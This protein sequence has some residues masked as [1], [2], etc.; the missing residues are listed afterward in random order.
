[1]PPIEMSVD[2]EAPTDLV[3]TDKRRS[4]FTRSMRFRRWFA[5]SRVTHDGS[6]SGRPIMVFRGCPEGEDRAARPS[7]AIFWLTSS[8]LNACFFEDG[9]LQNA[10][11]R[12]HRPLVITEAEFLQNRTTP[13]RIAADARLQVEMGLA[14]WDGVIFE[15]IVDGSHPSTV[16]AVFPRKGSIAH[17][18]LI[19]GRTTYGEDGMPRFSGLQPSATP[20]SFGRFDEIGRNVQAPPAP[21]VPARMSPSSPISSLRAADLSGDRLS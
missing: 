10:F 9:E 2:A 11:V 4:A 8:R 13:D 12:L 17:A 15:D 20:V 16:Y 19:V 18:A 1:M 7:D 21:L 5:G 3:A 6:A 14:T